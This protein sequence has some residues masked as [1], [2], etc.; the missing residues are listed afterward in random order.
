MYKNL[1]YYLSKCRS[2]KAKA[3]IKAVWAAAQAA[4]E[5]EI[6]REAAENKRIHKANKKR[7]AAAARAPNLI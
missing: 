1:D 6:A 5:S 7:M 4:K 3:N 2:E